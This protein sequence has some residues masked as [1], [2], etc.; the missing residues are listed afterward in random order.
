V[1]EAAENHRRSLKNPPKS[2]K[3]YIDALESQGLTQT[4]SVLRGYM[5]GSMD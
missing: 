1:M 4:A 2:V 5:A 3:E